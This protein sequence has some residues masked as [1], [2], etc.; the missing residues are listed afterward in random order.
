MSATEAGWT[1]EISAE[2]ANPSMEYADGEVKDDTGKNEGGMVVELVRYGF[3]VEDLDGDNLEE[4]E[5]HEV[6]RVAWARRHSSQPRRSFKKALQ[7]ALATAWT[8]ADALND[9]DKAVQEALRVARAE[10]DAH[11][12]TI[13]GATRTEQASSKPGTRFGALA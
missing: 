9:K 11:R 5:R 7:V 12:E 10:A 13:I 3:D 8:S 1:V 4:L 2:G 6:E